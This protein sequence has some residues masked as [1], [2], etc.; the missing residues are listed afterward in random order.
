[1]LTAVFQIRNLKL[2][3]EDERRGPE[4]V[5]VPYSVSQPVGWDRPYL[6]E[7]G[8]DLLI[9]AYLNNVDPFLRLIHKPT[10]FLCVNHFR[11]GIIP[12][13]EL[14]SCLL[15]TVYLLAL[16]SLSPAECAQL[17]EEK[18][19]L[20]STFREYVERG[21]ERLRITTTHDSSALLP[22]LLYIVRYA[23]VS[24]PLPVQSSSDIANDFSD[25]SLLDW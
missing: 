2:I 21:L 15:F 16:P 10:F 11:R 9:Q 22:L 13:P 1:M 18:A 12:D 8:S 23:F 7:A 6:P 19:V 14:F 25:L 20:V 17:G 5:F 3:L 24:A 4:A